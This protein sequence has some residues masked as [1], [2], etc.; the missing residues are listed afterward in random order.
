MNVSSGKSE[1]RKPRRQRFD[2]VSK[3]VGEALRQA[4]KEAD[5]S[6]AALGKKLRTRNGTAVDGT[7]ISSYERGEYVPEERLWPQLAAALGKPEAELF[8]SLLPGAARNTLASRLERVEGELASLRRLVE[9]HLDARAASQ[10]A[11]EANRAD[12]ES[13]KAQGRSRGRRASKGDRN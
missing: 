6:Q 4:R 11:R 5:L 12:R 10:A 1:P 3:E 9:D 7:K 8:G 13:R 2:E